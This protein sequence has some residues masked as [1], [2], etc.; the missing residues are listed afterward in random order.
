MHLFLEDTIIGRDTSLHTCCTPAITHHLITVTQ[1]SSHTQTPQ[2]PTLVYT[3]MIYIYSIVTWFRKCCK[4][5][6][7]FLNV[8]FEHKKRHATTINHTLLLSHLF[9]I[10]IQFYTMNWLLFMSYIMN[11]MVRFCVVIPFFFIPTTTTN[12]F[13]IRRIF[14]PRFY[15][16][17]F[18]LILILE[19]IV[20]SNDAIYACIQPFNHSIIFFIC[21]FYCS[22]LLFIG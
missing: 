18:F 4:I 9:K 22:I 19:Q 2:V 8:I 21:S 12:D 17:H 15:P 16:L 3:R 13:R 7:L 6:V 1:D 14:Y 20:N 10:S 5:T 11:Y